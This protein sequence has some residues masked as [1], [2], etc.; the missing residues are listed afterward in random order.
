MSSRGEYNLLRIECELGSALPL[1]TLVFQGKYGSAQ[2]KLVRDA[3][4]FASVADRS[5]ERR[6]PTMSEAAASAAV[7]SRVRSTLIAR[8]RR[9][10]ILRHPS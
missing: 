7:T 9:S 3:H 5:G 4:K 2:K 8:R 10:R 6:A 1:T